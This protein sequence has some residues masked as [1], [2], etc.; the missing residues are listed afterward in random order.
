MQV[1]RCAGAQVQSLNLVSATP[2]SSSL[3]SCVTLS[4]LASTTESTTSVM[5]PGLGVVFPLQWQRAVSR[6]EDRGRG[7]A[8]GEEWGELGGEGHR[9]LVW[10]EGLLGRWGGGVTWR[11][12]PDTSSPVEQ[13][14]VGLGS[15]SL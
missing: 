11:E 9:R 10:R 4:C 6:R 1:R 3:S 15:I 8:R 5:P 7:R 14:A 12:V 2:P 13:S